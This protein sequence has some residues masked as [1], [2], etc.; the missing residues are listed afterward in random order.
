MCKPH[1]G[2]GLVVMFTSSVVQLKGKHCQHPIA[3]MGVTHAWTSY[4]ADFCVI[5]RH[6]VF[7]REPNIEK[8]LQQI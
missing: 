6:S 7:S 1:Y 4:S 2:R 8:I 5:V 3:V